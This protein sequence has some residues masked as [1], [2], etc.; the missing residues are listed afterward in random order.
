MQVKSITECSEGSILQY[1]RASLSYHSSLR[2]GCCPFL[3]GLYWLCYTHM[4]ICIHVGTPLIISK[5][6]TSEIWITLFLAIFDPR[7]SIVKSVFDCRLSGVKQKKI[8]RQMAIENIVSSDL[9][10]AFITCS[11]HFRLPPIRCDKGAYFMV[12]ESLVITP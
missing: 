11:E 8:N 2:P 10:Y 3:S 5:F 7:S 6:A 4:H 9:W 1:F 12:I